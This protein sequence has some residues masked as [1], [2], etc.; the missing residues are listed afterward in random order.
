MNALI[1]ESLTH[2]F[3]FLLFMWILKRYAWGPLLEV[4]DARRQHIRDRIDAAEQA[5]AAADEERRKLSVRRQEL[6]AQVEARLQESLRQARKIAQDIEQQARE[7][8][9][10][11]LRTA[12]KQAEA[13]RLSAKEELQHETAQLALEAAEKLLT[14]VMNPALH[15]RLVSKM[16]ERVDSGR[17]GHKL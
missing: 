4:M 8:A 11:I 13:D 5:R 9:S 14:D 7:E 10:R 2:I 15:E 12:R 3:S 1:A 6:E 17:G 16:L